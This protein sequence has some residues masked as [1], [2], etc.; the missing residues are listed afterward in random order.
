MSSAMSRDKGVVCW[1]YLDHPDLRTPD[2]RFKH[3]IDLNDTRRCLHLS[4]EGFLSS[5]RPLL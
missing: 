3:Y 4:L 1:S 5:L 2:S